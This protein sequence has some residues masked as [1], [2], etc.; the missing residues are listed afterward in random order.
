MNLGV[1]ALQRFL[2]AYPAH[3]RAVRAAYEI[4]ATQRR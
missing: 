4:G 3:P 2:S 1:A